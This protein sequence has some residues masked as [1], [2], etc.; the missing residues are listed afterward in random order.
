MQPI[1]LHN[2]N[3]L[4]D[5]FLYFVM[6]SGSMALRG[7][8]GSGRYAFT[9][10]SRWRDQG[11]WRMHLYSWEW[12]LRY[13][14]Q[15]CPSIFL[16][17]CI[18]PSSR[19]REDIFGDATLQKPPFSKVQNKVHDLPGAQ[20]STLNCKDLHERALRQPDEHFPVSWRKNEKMMQRDKKPQL[21]S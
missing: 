1:A 2:P 7:Q 20:G 12:G 11:R 14:R 15:M 9:S 6:N 17:S 13:L 5:H 18:F 21:S 4:S 3:K 19:R 8:A 16:V 10:S